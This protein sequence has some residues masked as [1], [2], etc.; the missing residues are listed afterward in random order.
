LVARL[1][2]VSDFGLGSTLVFRKADLD[3]MGG[4]QEIAAYLADDYQLGR[5]LHSLGLRNV[6]SQLVVSTRLS[7]G[8]WRAAW[9][10]QVRWAR[11]IRLSRGGGYLGLPVTFATIWAGVAAVAGLWWLSAL[12]VAVR[13]AMAITCGWF[14]LRS[15]DVL[16]YSYAIPLR[17][18]W[19]VSVWSAGLF[20]HN[21]EWRDRYLRLD[22]EGRIIHSERK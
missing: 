3:R 19:G 6:V 10:H 20:G 18:L 9:R 13:L 22:S 14:V 1:F 11:T 21:V 7:A 16:K 5:M 4:F 15:A 2:G 8:S 17:D 12:L